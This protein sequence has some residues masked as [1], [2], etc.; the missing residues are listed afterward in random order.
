MYRLPQLALRLTQLPRQAPNLHVNNES[1]RA[2]APFELPTLSTYPI[3][4]RDRWRVHRDLIDASMALVRTIE[5]PVTSGVLREMQQ[6][7][8]TARAFVE[9]AMTQPDRDCV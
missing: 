5:D 3:K 2:G 7:D 4:P 1:A 6:H 8:E 9:R